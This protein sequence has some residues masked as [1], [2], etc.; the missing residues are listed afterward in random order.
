M[1]SWPCIHVSVLDLFTGILF[2]YL[3]RKTRAL[4]LVPEKVIDYLEPII[5][6]RLKLSVSTSE[7]PWV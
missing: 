3:Q 4:S 7:P 2:F 1:A 5:A 6:Y